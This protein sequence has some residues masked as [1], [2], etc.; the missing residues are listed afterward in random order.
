MKKVVEVIFLRLQKRGH[1]LTPARKMVVHIFASVSSPITALELL[2]KLVA[3]K[4]TVH[5][6]TIYR[7]L[8][9]LLA[10][11]IIHTIEF[12]DGQKRYELSGEHH[13][14]IV[15]RR[16]SAVVDVSLP[17]EFLSLQK[18]IARETKYRDI[19]HALE[20]FGLCRR[21]K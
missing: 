18:T 13:H 14:H 15:C 10:E 8:A 12:G 19:S 7:E 21:C 17:D 20:F 1:R 9:V 16:C 2:E 11:N 3:K 5:K 6:T 4:I